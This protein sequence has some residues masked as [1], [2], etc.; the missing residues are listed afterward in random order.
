MHI[1]YYDF[2]YRITNAISRSR[3]FCYV[4]FLPIYRTRYIA[5]VKYSL[6]ISGEL[7]ILTIISSDQELQRPSSCFYQKISRLE[8]IQS[9]KKQC[10]EIFD[11]FSLYGT[12]LDE[13]EITDVDIVH[14]KGQC[15][16]IFD[17][18]LSKNSTWAQYERV[19]MKLFFFATIFAK[20]GKKRLSAQSLTTRTQC[21]RSR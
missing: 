1:C 7:D 19:F 14:L 11:K 21:R 16:E 15:R 12:L 20:I 4:I 5:E 18:F 9:L 10:L 8:Q 17:T 3:Y 2:H 13:K 6:P